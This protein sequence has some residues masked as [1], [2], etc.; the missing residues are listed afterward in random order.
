MMYRL[1]NNQCSLQMLNRKG[2]GGLVLAET[3]AAHLFEAM[4]VQK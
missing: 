3:G 2:E 1:Y 4:L